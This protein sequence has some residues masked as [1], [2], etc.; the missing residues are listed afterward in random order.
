MKTITTGSEATLT[1]FIYYLFI[2][3]YKGGVVS[4]LDTNRFVN[5]KH[6]DS[7]SKNTR[8]IQRHQKDTNK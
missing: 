1:H 4:N 7:R 8:Q 5:M 6:F 3:Q 2:Y